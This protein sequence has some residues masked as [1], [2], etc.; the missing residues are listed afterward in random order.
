MGKRVKRLCK[1]DSIDVM[2]WL[3]VVGC[4]MAYAIRAF[5]LEQAL[6]SSVWHEREH[7]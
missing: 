7:G 5:N 2:Q 3:A 4:T 1:C 6:G